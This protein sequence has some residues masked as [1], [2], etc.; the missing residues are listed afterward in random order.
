MPGPGGQGSPT[1]CS[2]NTKVVNSCYS[3]LFPSISNHLAQLTEQWTMKD[4]SGLPYRASTFEVFVL[5]PSG[6]RK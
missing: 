1:T 3:Q 5:N 4:R 6:R 2:G